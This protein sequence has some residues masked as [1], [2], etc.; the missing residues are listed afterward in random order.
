M[1]CTQEKPSKR[2]PTL[3]KRYLVIHTLNILCSCFATLRCCPTQDLSS[4]VERTGC[5]DQIFTI[6]DVKSKFHRIITLAG[7]VEGDVGSMFGEG[8][9]KRFDTGGTGSVHARQN[10]DVNVC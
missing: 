4:K 3:A 9:F 10:N 5:T 7:F 2:K 6:S 1:N 8:S